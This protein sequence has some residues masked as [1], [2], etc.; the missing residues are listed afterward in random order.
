MELK[1]MKNVKNNLILTAMCADFISPKM[2]I[3]SAEKFKKEC[4]N[5]FNWVAE[6]VK[7]QD[8]I[9]FR[10]SVRNGKEIQQRWNDRLERNRIKDLVWGLGVEKTKGKI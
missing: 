6:E 7:N 9:A 1:S 4:P 3:E 10:K 8:W 2:P 5:A